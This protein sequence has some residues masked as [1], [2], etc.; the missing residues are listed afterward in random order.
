MAEFDRIKLRRLDG[1]LLL[2]FLGLLRHRKAVRVA[3]DLGLTPSTISH[4][5]ARLRDIFGD[6]LFLRRADGLD[7]T[8]EALRL[9]PEVAAALARLDEALAGARPF[10]PATAAATVRLSALDYEVAALFPRFVASVAAQAPGLSFAVRSADAATALRLL[11]EGQVDLA[12]GFF[13]SPPDWADATPLL[14]EDYL[15][16]ARAGHPL[17]TGEITLDA[18]CAARHLIVAPGGELSGIVDTALSRLG[19]RR[20]VAFA[21]PQFLAGLALVA[22]SDLVAT[23]PRRIVL[24]HAAR[25]GLVWRD[26]PVALR[27]FT[28][29]MLRHRRQARSPLLAWIAGAL[30]AA[31]EDL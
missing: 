1:T 21:V 12:L 22:E 9:G 26:P 11:D 5:L 4:A 19:R 16:V 10:D 24:A 7:P 27:S 8:A 13:W 2:V 31:A 29:S 3:E 23:V 30:V 15:T 28:S 18:F 20:T 25:F 14:T 6:E 17:M